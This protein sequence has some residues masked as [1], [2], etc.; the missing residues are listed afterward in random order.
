M[1]K[2]FSKPI[3]RTAQILLLTLIG[4]T[5]VSAGT[6]PGLLNGSINQRV[7]QSLN[8]MVQDVYA[9]EAPAEKRAVIERFLNKA[10]R[11]A[12]LAAKLPFLTDENHAAL[13]FLQGKF[14]RYS[15]ELNGVS[16]TGTAHNS[17]TGVPGGDLNDFASFMQ[18]DL[19]QAGNGVYLSTGAIIIVLLIILIIL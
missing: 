12:A 15:A 1:P 2:L 11:G 17:V 14:D 4:A 13:N 18:Q 10:E 3:L 16:G 7:K 8:T 5:A 6:E 19:E 9:A